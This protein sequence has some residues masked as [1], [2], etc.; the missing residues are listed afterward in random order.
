ME[1]ERASHGTWEHIAPQVSKQLAALAFPATR[2]V[3][4]ELALAQIGQQPALLQVFN[5]LGISQL[6]VHGHLQKIL[7]KPATIA[8]PIDAI[9]L[10]CHASGARTHRTYHVV[11]CTS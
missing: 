8:I 9:S 5:E 11:S 2:Q 3:L 10:D 4:L 7:H 6:E 1:A